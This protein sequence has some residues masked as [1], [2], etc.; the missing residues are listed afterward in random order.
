VG[1][2]VIKQ[3]DG[4]LAVFSSF[5]DTFVVMDATPDEV[6]E[7]FVERQA[8]AERRRVRAILDHVMADNSRAAYFQFARTWDEACRLNQ[9]HGGDLAYGA[10]SSAP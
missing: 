8:E 5:T 2:Q 7:W 6:V 10:A 9:E 4:R 1:H 3:P